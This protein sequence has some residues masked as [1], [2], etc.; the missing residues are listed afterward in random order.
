MRIELEQIRELDQESYAPLYVQLADRLANLV[1]SERVPAGTRLP[2]ESACERYFKVSR[3]TV[4]QALQK[5]TYEGLIVREHGRGTFVAPFRVDHDIAF[6]FEEEMHSFHL[7]IEFR[8]ISWERVQPPSS[9][10]AALATRRGDPVWRLER[11]R[12]V[13]GKPISR[14]IRYLP[15][16]IGAKLDISE[17]RTEPVY[18]LLQRAA[19]QRIER[20]S[21]KVSAVGASESD[22]AL[23][24]TK[25][26]TPLLAREHVYFGQDEV[27]VLHGI[28]LFLG[29]AYSFHFSTGTGQIKMG[30]KFESL[31]RE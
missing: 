29:E 8:V 4:R 15:R 21:Y 3:V 22:A 31:S 18:R 24:Q 20:I 26:G 9:V 16:A 30:S 5:L 10:A 6:S 2:S 14:E 19:K 28:V 17:L 7:P 13:S 25:K 23:L 27:P 11:V 1:R 12:L